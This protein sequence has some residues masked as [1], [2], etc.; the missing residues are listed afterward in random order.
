MN[1]FIK[2]VL[3]CCL[4]VSLPLQAAF[5]HD[6]KLKWKT[7]E[8]ANFLIHYPERNSGSAVEVAEIVERVHPGI[9]NKLNWVPKDKTHVVITDQYDDVN[10]AATPYPAN[11]IWLRLTPPKEGGRLLD[12]HS[13]FLETLIVHEYLHIVHLDK[14]AGFPKFLRKVF[15]RFDML[16]FAPFPNIYQPLWIIE[17]LATY[18]ESLVEPHAGRGNSKYYRALMRHEI[19]SQ[20]I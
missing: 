8:T 10:G 7:A 17:G 14:V 2:A 6:P 13:N 1:K 19:S 9:T 18:N 12:N 5:E 4:I 3:W 20:R 11:T 15:G 16:A